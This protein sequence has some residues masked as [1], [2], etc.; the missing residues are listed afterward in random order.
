MNPSSLR[1]EAHDALYAPTRAHLEAEAAPRARVATLDPAE[2]ICGED[3][4]LIGTARQ[5]VYIDR[6]HLSNPGAAPVARILAN[7]I[8]ARLAVDQHDA[9]QI[10]E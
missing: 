10:P 5:A 1:R 3:I 4:C 9:G 8:A 2:R 6:N 7:Q